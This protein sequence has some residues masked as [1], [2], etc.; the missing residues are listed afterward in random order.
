MSRR[1]VRCGQSVFVFA[2]L[3]HSDLVDESLL[4]NTVFCDRKHALFAGNDPQ[5]FVP[6]LREGN[7]RLKQILKGRHC[8]VGDLFDDSVFIPR[9]TGP[10][11]RRFEWPDAASVRTICLRIRECDEGGIHISRGECLEGG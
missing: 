2:P 8:E 9:K 11:A 5:R 6:Y 3:H 4:T 7:G 1:T 10:A